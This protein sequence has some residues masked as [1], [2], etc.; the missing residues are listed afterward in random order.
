M[1][2]FF[3]HNFAVCHYFTVC[4]IAGTQ[5]TRILC[6][7]LDLCRVF[8]GLTHS[9][10]NH[11]RVPNLCR[12]LFLLAHGKRQVCH[13]PMV[14]HTAIWEFPVVLICFYLGDKVS[15]SGIKIASFFDV[16]KSQSTESF[17]T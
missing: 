1:S 6:R 8:F 14:Q 13:V 16:T 12:V 5:E 17:L 9:K 11:C 7:V 4:N 3:L 15:T 10:D 2:T